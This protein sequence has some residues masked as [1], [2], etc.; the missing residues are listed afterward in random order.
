MHFILVINPHQGATFHSAMKTNQNCS[1]WS[2]LQV[3][4][5]RFG[6]KQ[7]SKM[8]FDHPPKTFERV[9]DLGGCSYL[10]QGYSWN[11]IFL[12]VL[13]LGILNCIRA[14]KIWKNFLKG[15]LFD[16]R[17]NKVLNVFLNFSQSQFIFTLNIG[18]R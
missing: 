12:T 13:L 18:N 8:S 14:S 15:F 16:I 9:L 1:A 4:R 5:P 7:N 10:L 17:A 2:K 3:P 6:P 11:L